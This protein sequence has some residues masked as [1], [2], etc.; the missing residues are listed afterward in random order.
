MASLYFFNGY[1]RLVFVNVLA[2]LGEHL[3]DRARARRDDFI[4]KLHG[5]HDAYLVTGLD[6]VPRIDEFRLS[7]TGRGIKRPD[8]R[9]I[10]GAGIGG[11]HGCAGA[12]DAAVSAG[13]AGATKG[14]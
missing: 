5:L 11:C 9:R 4:E 1:K 13:F 12:A 14:A 6:A 8:D 7:R 3:D 2:V 10:D